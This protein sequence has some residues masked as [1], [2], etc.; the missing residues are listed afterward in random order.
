MDVISFG[1]HKPY[2]LES[3]VELFE[4]F[5]DLLDQLPGPVELRRPAHVLTLIEDL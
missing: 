5:H 3:K 2:S 4:L 1:A